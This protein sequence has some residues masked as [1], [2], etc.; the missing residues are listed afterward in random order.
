MDDILYLSGLSILHLSGLSMIHL[1]GRFA[2]PQVK[3]RALPKS[4]WSC[5]YQ[6]LLQSAVI[7]VWF[8][9]E[10]SSTVAGEANLFGN[11]T[12]ARFTLLY[13]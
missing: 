9:L 12:V 5:V 8:S 10:E 4:K 3:V 6:R 1:F 7:A 13:F 2:L 11:K